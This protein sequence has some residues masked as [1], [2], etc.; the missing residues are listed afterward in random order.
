M[1]AF[2]KLMDNRGLDRIPPEAREG[3]PGI[4]CFWLPSVEKNGGG[5]K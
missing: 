3:E 2:E 5:Y 4:G 1:E